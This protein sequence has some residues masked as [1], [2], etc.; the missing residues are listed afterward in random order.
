MAESNF[1]FLVNALPDPTDLEAGELE[2]VRLL[3]EDNLN[4]TET[5]AFRYLLYRNDNKNLLKLLRKRDGILPRTASH[6]YTPAVFTFEDL[7]DMLIDVYAG[8]VI[9]PE[10]LDQFLNEEKHAGWTV[11]ERENRLLELY[12]DAGI[13]HPQ[14]FIRSMFLFKRDL[15]NVLLALNARR[16]GFKITRITVG[17]YDLP[18]AL[19]ASTQADFGLGGEHDYLGQLAHLLAEGKLVELEQ[20]I[21]ELLLTHCAALVRGE[22]FSLNFVLYYFLD[23]SLRHRWRAL[24]PDQGARALGDLVEDIIRTA[25]EPAESGVIK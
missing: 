7:D 20:T 3:I 24:T 6:F 13:C 16:Q 17:D 1:Y 8:E 25:G 9:V 4:Q 18:V 10:Y 19:A 15:K 21:D 23:L 22:I 11:R 5:H 14:E 2:A 12:Y